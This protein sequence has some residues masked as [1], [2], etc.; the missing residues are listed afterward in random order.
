MKANLKAV[1]LAVMGGAFLLA[2]GM[3]GTPAA[4]QVPPGKEKCYGIA[5]K[6]QDD[7]TDSTGPVPGMSTV[8]YQGDAYK[9][10]TK[11]TCTA[12]DTPYGPGSLTPIPDRP[13]K[14]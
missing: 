2:L 6:G 7:G 5:K 12:T 9:F 11:G 8:D 10:V 4:A 14:R 3:T 1:S 13:P